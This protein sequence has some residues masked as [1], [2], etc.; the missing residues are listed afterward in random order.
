MSAVDVAVSATMSLDVPAIAGRLV[1]DELEILRKHQKA[2]VTEVK[3]KW[4]GWKYAGRSPKSVGRSR[5]GWKGRIQGTKHPFTL[6]IEDKARSFYGGKPY[7]SYVKRSGAAEEEYLIVFKWLVF[8]R[9]PK[10]ES[11]LSAAI[12]KNIGTKRPMKEVN[13]ST[14]GP[15]S[16][17]STLT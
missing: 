3:A 8:E 6:T 17:G 14:A 7:V 9:L 16:V 13:K 1:K 12:L 15:R 2:I 4:T 10:L 5:A 11:E